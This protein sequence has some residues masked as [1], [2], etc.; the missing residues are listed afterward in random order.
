MS[1]FPAD[2]IYKF[3]F[4]KSQLGLYARLAGVTS[5]QIQ[6]KRVPAHSGDARYVKI[7]AQ[8]QL[9]GCQT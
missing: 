5:N 2:Q 1:L 4:V 8:V 7:T 3:G 9:V 6:C